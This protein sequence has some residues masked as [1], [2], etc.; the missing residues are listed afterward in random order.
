MN[1]KNLWILILLIVGICGIVVVEGIIKPKARQMEMQYEAEQ[2]SPYTHDISRTLKYRNKYMGNAGNI[3]NL[4]YSLPYHDL[5]QSFQLYPD[6]LT[7]ELK[8]NVQSEQLEEKKLQ[9]MLLYVP[10]ANFVMIDNLQAL[11]MTFEDAVYT[12]ERKE[13]EKWYGE[14]GS[15]VTLQNIQSWRE[16]VQEK[17]KDNQFI[18]QFNDQLVTREAVK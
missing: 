17:M 4:N 16:L 8:Y 2:K 6:D 18:Q 13:V 9:E 3:A 14:E 15:L 11:R 10:T 7:V 5:N 12:I 1:R